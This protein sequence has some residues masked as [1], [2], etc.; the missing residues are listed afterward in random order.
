MR[1][2]RRKMYRFVATL[3]T[4]LVF[5]AA[6][7]DDG[8]GD[9]RDNPCR[10]ITCSGHGTCLYTYEGIPYC[11]CDEHYEMDPDLPTNCRSDGSINDC[12]GPL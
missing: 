6:G 12:R 1:S 8:D 2:H 4:A 3:A 10:D 7:C 5:L 9:P 11:K